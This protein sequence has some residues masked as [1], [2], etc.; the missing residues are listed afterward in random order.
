MK[1]V[2]RCVGNAMLRGSFAYSTLL[3]SENKYN[4]LKKNEKLEKSQAILKLPIPI[5]R[6]INIYL[7]FAVFHFTVIP[8]TL[9]KFIHF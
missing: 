7:Y 4:I 6:I 8:I 3:Y 5:T 9:S 1:S 2:Q